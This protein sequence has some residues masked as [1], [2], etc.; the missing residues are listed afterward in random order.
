MR[1]KVWQLEVRL[2]PTLIWAEGRV[3]FP[4]DTERLGQARVRQEQS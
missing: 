4:S 3:L 2:F 1:L